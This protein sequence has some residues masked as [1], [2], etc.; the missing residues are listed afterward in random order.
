MGIKYIN[1]SEEKYEC[2][3]I[4]TLNIDTLY[5]D[6]DNVCENLGYRYKVRKAVDELW[7]ECELDYKDDIIY[8]RDELFSY[9]NECYYAKYNIDIRE[10]FDID[11]NSGTVPM[12]E[13]DELPYDAV[14]SSSVI[15]Y[16]REDKKV[17]IDKEKAVAIIRKT[18][19]SVCKRLGIEDKEEISRSFKSVYLLRDL[20][21]AVAFD[22]R[23]SLIAF[24]ECWDNYILDNGDCGGLLRLFSPVVR[25][26]TK[27]GVDRDYVLLGYVDFK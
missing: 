10:L 2:M 7:L 15:L 14:V 16:F 18:Y 26:D 23:E 8:Y 11:L 3:G 4:N 9:F 12:L 5:R 21:V 25:Y 19:V 17:S 13:F 1:L 6:L 24:I 20:K 22:N 27:L